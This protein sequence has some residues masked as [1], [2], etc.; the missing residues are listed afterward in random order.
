MYSDI[1]YIYIHLKNI[2][3]HLSMTCYICM[4]V[5]IQYYNILYY[6]IQIYKH[7]VKYQEK[8]PT[9]KNNQ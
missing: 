7:I 9:G 2:V 4:L 1:M 8:N 3:I 5:C 6:I